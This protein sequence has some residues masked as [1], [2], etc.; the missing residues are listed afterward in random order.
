MSLGPLIA[1]IA[2]HKAKERAFTS[3]DR[4]LRE[5][6]ALCR[7]L[8]DTLGPCDEPQL[9]SQGAPASHAEPVGLP[10]PVEQP[11]AADLP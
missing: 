9:T 10:A 5:H 1:G 6:L 7:R 8:D 3:F 4:S 2:E 11:A